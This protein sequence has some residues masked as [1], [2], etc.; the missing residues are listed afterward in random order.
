MNVQIGC[1]ENFFGGTCKFFASKNFL[2]LP[3]LKSNE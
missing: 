1:V 2:K 3:N